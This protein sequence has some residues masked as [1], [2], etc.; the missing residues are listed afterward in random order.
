M[1][2]YSI[3]KKA[4]AVLLHQLFII[5]FVGAVYSEGYCF[6]NRISEPIELITAAIIISMVGSFVCL[7]Y[8]T[9]V[10]GQKSDD[11]KEIYYRPIDKV[12]SDIL[13]VIFALFIS[14][15]MKII[16]GVKNQEFGYASL[17]MTVGTVAYIID[18]VFL[19]LYS[20]I[21]RKMKGDIL[22]K[23]SLCF[24]C[25]SHVKDLI[26]GRKIHTRKTSELLQI[27]DALEKIS[28]GALDTT[29][30]VDHF[31]GQQKSIAYAVNNIRNGMMNSVNESL[32]NE[33]LKAELIT[34]VSHDIKTPLT[35][36]I[37]YVNLLKLEDIES[38]NAKNYIK[39]LDEKAQRLKQLTEDL[40]ETSKITTGNITLDMQT[41][42]MVEL[43]YQTGGEFNERFEKRNLT[44]VTKIAEGP[45]HV[46]ADGRYLYRSIEN[47]YTNA[48]KYAMENTRVY[49]E[50]EENDGKAIFTIKNVSQNSLEIISDGDVDL[51][52]RFVR[53]EISRTTEG[54]GLG[55]SIAKSLTI[56]MGGN[57]EIRMD[58]D[59]FI[60][61]ISYDV[62]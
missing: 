8:L 6:R 24:V 48:A 1:R 35:S 62:A 52:E 29:L 30:D 28:D 56:L 27:K 58:G 31:H 47:L 45:I 5:I 23:H 9:N 38:E 37:N 39:V 32:K 19:I 55:L 11:D 12:Y 53:G 44:I 26:Q 34:N 22:F 20:S 41:L 16:S 46:R 18:L 33:K 60:A 57:F 54:S 3:G 42:D 21:I 50:L 7:A 59:L 13:L 40:V 14:G 61:E 10:A 51:T 49:V 25:G 17:I 15:M 36:I 2:T 4:A 43:L